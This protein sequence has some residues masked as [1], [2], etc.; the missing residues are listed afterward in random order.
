MAYVDGFLVPVPKDKME[1][2]L[3][4][5]RKCGKVW[6][7]HGALQYRET[8][9]DDV[10]VGVHTSFPQAVK[11]EEG[12]VVVFSWIVYE[13]RA[14]RDRVNEAVMADPRLKE[15]MDPASMPFDGKRLVFGGFEMLI[16]M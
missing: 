6:R 7:E 2:Y 4:M 8:V 9:A 5:S 10:K 1:A 11:L 12:E 14:E 15:M 3:D 13:S 16:D